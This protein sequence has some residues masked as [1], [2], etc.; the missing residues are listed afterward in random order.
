[1]TFVRSV[2]GNFFDKLLVVALKS[3][4]CVSVYDIEG[5]KIF[6]KIHEKN[7]NRGGKK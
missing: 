6:L 2:N 4:Q 3:G 7:N 1:M 5:R